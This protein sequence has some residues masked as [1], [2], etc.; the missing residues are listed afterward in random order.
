LLAD[1]RTQYKL[2]Y[3]SALNLTGQHPLVASVDLPDGTALTS[4][5]SIVALRVEPP[6]VTL[7]DLPAQM[8]QTVTPLVVPFAVD[9]ADGHPRELRV[10]ELVVDGETVDRQT[11]MTGVLRWPTIGYTRSGEHVVSVRAVDELGLSAESAPRT[12]TVNVTAPIAAAAMTGL[13]SPPGL[14]VLAGAGLALAL[15]LFFVFRTRFARPQPLPVTRTQPAPPPAPVV[16]PAPQLGAAVQPESALP[17]VS[18]RLAQAAPA[19]GDTQPRAPLA[20]VLDDTRPVQPVG[21]A[22]RAAEPPLAGK[23]SSPA[24]PS[25][26]AGAR[27]PVVEKKELGRAYLEVLEPGGGGAPRPDI[28]ILKAVLKIGRDPAQSEAAFDDRSV[29]RLHAR[30]VEEGNAFKIYDERSTSGTW[31]NLEQIPVEGGREL[32]DGDVIN[33]GRVQLRFRRRQ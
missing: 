12:V 19:G 7:G 31:V 20:H 27:R 14:A 11:V 16:S 5:P 25:S 21:I 30:L 17:P 6:L 13:F 15:G 18:A 22:T 23:A 9:F 33:L 4:P 8:D 3:R 10:F 28:E 24:A 32:K 1:Q 29:S 2:S 26:R